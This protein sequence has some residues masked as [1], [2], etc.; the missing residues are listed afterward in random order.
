M[1]NYGPNM[2][3][4]SF[5]CALACAFPALVMSLPVQKPIASGTDLLNAQLREPGINETVRFSGPGRL[6]ALDEM[7]D[8]KT[9]FFGEH[10]ATLG[11]QA[12]ARTYAP[13]QHSGTQMG[14][15]VRV[16]K[17]DGWQI[18]CYASRFAE[19]FEGMDEAQLEQRPSDK[20]PKKMPT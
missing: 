8:A 15:H 18:S 6:N 2:Q 16:R 20:E 10:A 9:N 13:M 1:A 5:L 7:Q 4:L 14:K 3:Y 17:E 12:C 11:A 19:P